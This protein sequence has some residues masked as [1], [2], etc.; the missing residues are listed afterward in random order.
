MTP[1]LVKLQ[2]LLFPTESTRRKMVRIRDALSRWDV[3]P[4]RVRTDPTRSGGFSIYNMT[5]FPAEFMERVTK[6][7]SA[8]SNKDRKEFGLLNVH[9]GHA[10]VRLYE[11]LGF[12][13]DGEAIPLRSG[14]GMSIQP[15]LVKMGQTKCGKIHVGVR[16][17]AP[18]PSLKVVTVQR[19]VRSVVCDGSP[20]A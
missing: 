14:Q 20:R 15:F 16:W 18:C 3:T 2:P 5:D 17:L 9:E 7:G 13:F 1:G 4:M 10:L 11:S 12:R 6:D 8:L 19:A